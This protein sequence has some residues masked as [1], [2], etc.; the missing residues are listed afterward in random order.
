[1]VQHCC[2]SR[3]AREGLWHFPQRRLVLRR[4][5]EA[6]LSASFAL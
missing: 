4:T 2:L 5:K 6:A 3:L 1:M